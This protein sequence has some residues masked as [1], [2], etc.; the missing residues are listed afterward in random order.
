MV[1][2]VNRFSTGNALGS[3]SV[4]FF[5]KGIYSLVKLQPVFSRVQV[6]IFLFYST[7]PTL[8]KRII[9]GPSFAIHVNANLVGFERFYP[10]LTCVLAALIGANDLGCSILLYSLTEQ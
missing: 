10:M 4:I 2:E 5:N 6:N 7:E 3:S 1:V 9:G 8:Y